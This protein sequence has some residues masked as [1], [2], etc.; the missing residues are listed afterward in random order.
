MKRASCCGEP[1]PQRE[2]ARRPRFG[3]QPRTDSSFRAD[4]SAAETNSPPAD[5]EDNVGRG[6]RAVACTSLRVNFA[7]ISRGVSFATWIVTRKTPADRRVARSSRDPS[8]ACRVRPTE[9]STV[10]DA[11]IASG[12]MRRFATKS[13]EAQVLDG[14]LLF[15]RFLPSLISPSFRSMGCRNRN[16]HRER[17]IRVSARNQA[18][19]P[20]GP[21]LAVRFPIRSRNQT[22]DRPAV[23]VL[24][25]VGPVWVE[26][27]ALVQE[28]PRAIGSTAV[29]SIECQSPAS[30][31]SRSTVSLDHLPQLLPTGH[32]TASASGP[33]SIR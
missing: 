13:P 26:D 23:A 6:E 18:L 24:E 14:D 3:I 11:G 4:R 10:S 1:G 25:R 33:G 27:V 22:A 21:R 15:G 2:R 19:S 9:A 16:L 30:P 17:R 8:I 7:G 29:V 12:I 31:R 32:A 5:A 28:K 20:Q